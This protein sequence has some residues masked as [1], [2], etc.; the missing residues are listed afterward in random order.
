MGDVMNVHFQYKLDQTQ[1]TKWTDFWQNCKHAHAQQHVMFGEVEK[2]KGRIPIY[3]YGEN[4]G[5][6]ECTGIFSIRPLLFRNQF[7]IEAICLSGPTF[8]EITHV[9]DFLLQVISFFKNLNVGNI[10]IQP[11]WIYPESKEIES[12]LKKVGF[13]PYSTTPNFVNRIRR[14]HLDSKSLTALVNLQP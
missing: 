7:S 2:V 13:I 4:N 6:L 10:R 9:E 11:Y 14:R 12:I 8:D 3:I 1:K 5:N